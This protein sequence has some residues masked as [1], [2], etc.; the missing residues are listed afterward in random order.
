MRYWIRQAKR[1]QKAGR[2][3]DERERSQQRPPNDS[4][5]DSSNDPYAIL[6]VSPG[7]T[8]EEIRQAYRK[9]AS[10]YHPDKVSHL[11]Q[12]FAELSEKRF[13]EIQNAY[14]ILKK[15]K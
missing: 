12:E 13:K 9:L 1:Q 15:D 7:A 3:F 8:Q 6:G 11:G 14:Q 10:R 4:S 5:T 2:Q